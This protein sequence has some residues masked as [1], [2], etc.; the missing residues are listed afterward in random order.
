MTFNCH[1][2]VE[3]ADFKRC[4]EYIMTRQCTPHTLSLA[5]VLEMEAY[6]V[7]IGSWHTHGSPAVALF[8][9]HGRRYCIKRIMRPPNN[10]NGVL[11]ELLIHNGGSCTFRMLTGPRQGEIGTLIRQAVVETDHRGAH[12]NYSRWKLAIIPAESVT[13]HRHQGL[14][15]DA[16]ILTDDPSAMSQGMA[17]VALDRIKEWGGAAI[18]IVTETSVCVKKQRIA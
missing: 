11:A 12:F 6:I 3:V 15:Q 9:K 16:N 4:F 8:L 17:Y 14:T 10:C 13:F 18:A 5:P 7:G 2:N 1:I